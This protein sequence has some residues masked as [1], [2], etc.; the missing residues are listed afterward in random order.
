MKDEVSS[1]KTEVLSRR[2]FTRNTVAAA[3]ATLLSAPVA[4]AQR[5]TQ[6]KPDDL[7]APDWDEV[8]SRHAN[9]LRVYGERLT[10]QEKQRTLDILITNQRM[11]ISIRSY[12]VQNSDASALT[13][14]LVP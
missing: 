4:Q 5:N 11:L 2:S 7:P 3:A 10:T 12:I 13:L 6:T 1:Q 8:Q 9:L 14:R